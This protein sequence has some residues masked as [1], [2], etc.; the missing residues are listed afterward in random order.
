M[1]TGS[2]RTTSLA[3][4]YLAIPLGSGLGYMIAPKVTAISGDWRWSLCVTPAIV[5]S[6]HLDFLLDLDLLT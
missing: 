2:V 5:S 3:I 6:S 4:F 1:F